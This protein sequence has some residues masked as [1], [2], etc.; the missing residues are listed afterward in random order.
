MA[1]TPD[2]ALLALRVYS[3]PGATAINGDKELNRPA[4]P[5]GWTELEWHADNGKGFSYGVYQNDGE[6][7]IS[8]AGTNENID[9]VSNGTNGLGLSS[10]QT[11]EAA[12]A[13]LTANQQ[14]GSNITFTG[15]S[16]GGGLASVMAIWFDRPAVVFDEAPFELT[17]RNPL[18]IGATYTALTLAGFNVG[19][20][21]DYNGITDFAAREAKVSNYFTQDEALLYARL[22]WPTIVGS[23]DEVIVANVTDMTSVGAKGDLHSQALLTALVMSQKFQSATYASSR[24]LPLLM[25]ERLY[26]YSTKSD[27]ENVLIN[28]I[29]SEQGTGD[30]L[31]HFANDLQKL[32][33][34]IAGLNKAAQ[35]AI[36]A[37]G[38]EWYYWQGTDYAGKEFFTQTGGLLQ[39]TVKSG[40]ATSLK[41]DA[42]KALLYT[43]AWLDPLIQAD[44][45]Y[46]VAFKY[47]QW[48]VASGTTGITATALD[49]AKS[50]VFVG[51]DGGDT[52]TG[53][54]EG[55]L[56][57]G[58]GG[59]DTLTG[60]AGSDDLFGSEGNDI[61]NGGLG[62][63]WLYGG[64]GTDT[65]Q[66]KS[67]ELF[68]I[69]QDNDGTGVI[70]VDGTPL[71]GGKKAGDGYWISADKQWGYLLTSS[72]DL[73]VSKGSSPDKITIR[74]WQSGGGNQLGIVLNDAPATQPTGALFFN[75]DQRAKIIGAGNETQEGV[76][77]DKPTYG[78]YAWSE[79]SWAADG[80]LINGKAAPDFSDVIYATA[81]GNNGSVIHGYGGNDALSGSSGK[82][83]IFGDE[84][85]DLIGGGTG[86]DNIRGG[87][88]N[89]YI[90]SSATLNMSQRLRPTDSWSPPAGQEVYTQGALWGIYKDTLPDGTPVTM[91]SG[92]NS[93]TGTDSDVIDGGAGDDSIIAG[94]GDDRVQGG[95]GD[96]KID[97]L[98]GNDVLE[99]GDGKDIINGDGLIKDGFMNTLAAPYHGA[100]FVDGGA[101]DDQ[102]TGGGGNDVVYGG[103]GADKMLG[104]ASGKASEAD[105]L[106]VAYHGNDYLDGED[107]EDYIEGGGKN[108]T[109]YGG[110]DND[111]LWGDTSAVNV[112]TP[113][114]NAA[115]WGDDYLDGEDGDD[116]LVGGGKD[117][118]LYGGTGDDGIWGDES[119]P[120]LA[121]E[122]NGNDYLDGEDGN[123][124]MVGGG[125]DD[126]LYGGAGDD[127]MLGDDE[128]DK[129]AA[130]FQGADYLDGEDGSD[131]LVGGG[132]DDILLGGTG[133]D[134][135]DGGTGADYMEGGAG[136]DTYVV[137]SEGD[138]IVEAD[139][140]DETSAPASTLALLALTALAPS[141]DNVQSSV[142]YTLGTNLDNL[143]LTGTAA[144]NGAGNS[145]NNVLTG[146]IAAN[147]L[148]G[149]AGDDFYYVDNAADTV[150]ETSG[151]GNDTV[152]SSVSFALA[153]NVEQLQATGTAAIDLSGNTMD[154]GLFGNTESNVL[155][156]GTGNDYLVGNAGNDVYVF[157]RGDGQDSIN[158]TDFLRD[159]AQPDLLGATDTLRFGGGIAD[160]DVI[161]M[162]SGDN[163]ILRLKG[164]S[165]QVAVVG[166]YG[167]DVVNGTRI[168]DHKIDSVEFANGVVWDSSMIQTV[169]DRATNNHAPIATGTLPNLQARA[170]SVFSYTVPIDTI[171]DADVGDSITYSVKMS[172]GSAL[173][174]WLSFDA[175]TRTLSGTPDVGNIGNLQFALWGTDSYGAAAGEGVVITVRAANQSPLLSVPLDDQ[176]TKQDSVFT[177]AVPV[178]AF[179]DPDAGDVLTYS[180][181]L[182]DGS[183][184]PAWLTF[185]SA[186]QTF[187]GTPA[188]AGTLSV[189]LSA[190][191]GSLAMSDTF[192]IN[193]IAVNHAPV[194]VAALLD[195]TVAL[196]ASF[197]YAVPFGAVTDLDATDHLTW[198]ATQLNGSALPSW[199]SFDATTRSFSGT[200]PVLG[201]TSVKVVAKD[202]GNL[203]VFDVFDIAVQVPP[204][205]G[206]VGNDYMNGTADNDNI[207]GLAGSDTLIGGDGNDTL[208]GGDGSDN[209]FGNS[210][211]NIL[212]GG[213]GNDILTV[214]LFS[215]GDTLAG[216]AGDDILNVDLYNSGNNLLEG[217]AGNDTI[218]G[219]SARDTYLF[220]RGDGHDNI[221]E[222]YDSPVAYRNDR[223]VFGANILPSDVLATRA[224]DDMVFS[225][226]GGTDA[227]DVRSWF[228]GNDLTPYYSYPGWGGQIESIEFSD[229]T[230][231]TSDSLNAAFVTINGTNGNDTISGTGL[232]D[233][234]SGLDGD[235]GISGL[236]GNDILNGGLGNDTL[237]GGLG[238]DTL[239]GGAGN[240]LYLV[241]DTDDVVVELTNDGVDTVNSTIT[242]ALGVD[243]ENLTL[244]GIETIDGTGNTL[245]NVISGNDAD[246]TLTGGVG[247][248][249]LDG[250]AGI[251][252]LVGGA[253]NDTY[254]VDTATDL[255]TELSNQGTDQVR[256]SVS[257]TLAANL[258]N[259]TLTGTT[260]IDG[261]GN[262][263][264]NVITGNAGDNVLNGGAGADTMIGDAG[265]DTYL[266]N[267]ATDVV[268]EN[269]NEGTDSVKSSV[270][271]TLGADVENL[272]L[273]GTSAINGTGNT[274]NNTLTGNTGANILDGG[275]G[276]DTLVGGTGNDTYYVDNAGDKTTEASSAGTDTV[277][278]SINWTLA[279]NL[280]KLTLSGTANINATG[281]TLANVLTGNA[282][283]NFL[284][285]GTGTD[286][287]IGGLGNDTFVLDV[288]TD[289]VTEGLNAGTDTIQSKVTYTLGA[290]VENLTL[291]G[292]S[293]IKA[294]GNALDNVLTGNS[295]AN[296]LT[297]GAGNDTYV[298]GTGDTTV[299][300]ASAGTD[301][302]QSAITWTLATNV[303]NL[304][305][306][307]ATAINGTGNTSDNVL[308]GNSGVNTLTGNAGND[309]L[310]GGAG[311]DIL[312]G[313]TG[314]DT[315]WLGRGFGFDSVTENDTTAGNTDVAR[316][317]AGI[318]TDQLWFVK[319][320]NN[321][322]VSIIGTTDKLT[323]TNWYLGSQYH[324]EQ[325]KTS[326]GKTL[327]DSQ[328]Q[329]LVS[330]MAAF[331][332]PAAGQTTLSAS[333]AASLNPVIAANWQ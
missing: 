318:A 139:V 133:N 75:G 172:D 64:S 218:F 98:G 298:V 222:N 30:K 245:N 210:G 67:G 80:T 91:W 21:D 217:G 242:Y 304:T 273:T 330:A 42:N 241:D 186:T 263:T 161:G 301:T 45:G 143:T 24:V 256:S 277:I 144:I 40:N 173:P 70:T 197:T 240:D 269:A 188:I 265:N 142:T 141:I 203:S 164:A 26:A 257:L 268:T 31:T 62:G 148:T 127:T 1:S 288:A 27:K 48:N 179:T 194:L 100:D 41:P 262:S 123:D 313:G 249:V 275:S 147:V 65:Y 18:V 260:N 322:D 204:I 113:G 316:F 132:G 103:V 331:S 272:A 231:W 258:E 324:V 299:E 187:T 9:W 84:G 174:G 53:G 200:P 59:M 35:D 305:L 214:D 239:T 54:T 285:G 212:N 128:L 72:G 34:N 205:V 201:T 102:L 177:Y 176:I 225:V 124:F 28:F 196:G 243:V 107:G 156:G 160:F 81:A 131:Y 63:D 20:F 302:V 221:T 152:S 323:M 5:T 309:T 329:N 190:S 73:I 180:A 105:Y 193:V 111:N 85:D 293:V 310:N 314:N 254:I 37:Q 184:L 110:A 104:D 96:D 126:I 282:G 114:A 195:Q 290:N 55:D 289:V 192:D 228:T 146:N 185:D 101:G 191:D 43:S 120:A 219:G 130:E 38:I 229:G 292:T 36:I 129:V 23:T 25:D 325:F 51:A 198:T 94:G 79:T 283:D 82:D 332:P 134:Y 315:Y 281:N 297:G 159:T 328:V 19:A 213:D 61:L 170:G 162:R 270:S 7:V 106:D 251:D 112:D 208:D 230:V 237:D 93:P 153:D 167:A 220:N 52:F 99:G 259:L 88:G 274:L 326:D 286:T 250:G 17:A 182:S 157:K 276:A 246:N 135:L 149:G 311:A 321:L 78:T 181:T 165:D 22:A 317:D 32:G 66:L 97:G 119:A 280:E 264:A 58:G 57:I 296:V 306:T 261:T 29:R 138:V 284:D 216:G 3:T 215:F 16:L 235:D 312:V 122:S 300:A 14:Y 266:V 255:I 253:G 227:V 8:Y 71:T 319:T 234:L 56:I 95:T 211:H 92:S 158:N 207:Q 271:Y 10:A 247:D 44:G 86:S 115:L 278:S 189:M 121:G 11:T 50:Q 87:D 279:T 155:T 6:I 151:E 169:V 327:L 303:E 33:T 125:K 118:T 233:T 333:Y 68:D 171:T 15:H 76:T 287:L 154:N 175:L 248:D 136:D 90:N 69:I 291:T 308:L 77:A 238:T 83:D 294:T 307:G 60:G 295:A 109:L 223:L 267:V 226:S 46:S 178:G 236:R 12:L 183:A 89:D 74:N 252:K 140:A 224:G 39:Y 232:D 163:L 47:D 4:V 117:D 137:D 13:Y 206:T 168:S 145:L 150:I 108:D 49:A 202:S 209:L 244:S 320:G 166:Y 199:L 2:L 116:Q